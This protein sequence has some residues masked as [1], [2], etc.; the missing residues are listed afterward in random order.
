MS[1]LRHI[2]LVGLLPQVPDDLVDLFHLELVEPHDGPV[3]G[4][5]V[6]VQVVADDFPDLHLDRL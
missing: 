3:L 4:C 2:Y 6:L 1:A 5:V